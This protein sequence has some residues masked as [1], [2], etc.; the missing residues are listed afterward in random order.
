MNNSPYQKYL[1]SIR[2][3]L[4]YGKK[5][6]EF[7]KAQYDS[8]D[9]NSKASFGTQLNLMNRQKDESLFESLNPLSVVAGKKGKYHEKPGAH[10]DFSQIKTNNTT[11]YHYIT[12][13]F[14]D[15]KNS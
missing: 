13:M 9:G 4:Q 2:N 10:P 7:K 12:S 3:D 1:E 11:E 15:I 14:I 6:G 8:F 5:R